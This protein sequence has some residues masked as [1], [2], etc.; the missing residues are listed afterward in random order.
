MDVQAIRHGSAGKNDASATAP[1]RQGNDD[2]NDRVIE[3]SIRPG[4][5]I[6]AGRLHT[7]VVLA[8][9]IT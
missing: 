7:R 4:S 5:M 2:V 3:T 1:L 8:L 6:C 9:G